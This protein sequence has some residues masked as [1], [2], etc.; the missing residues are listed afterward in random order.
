MTAVHIPPTARQIQGDACIHALY[1]PGRLYFLKR[2]DASKEEAEA[3]RKVCVCIV[4]VGEKGVGG[5][6]EIS[7]SGLTGAKLATHYDRQW[8]M[9]C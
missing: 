2:T 4:C 5:T 9:C 1:A 8:L 3:I 6:H 7:A